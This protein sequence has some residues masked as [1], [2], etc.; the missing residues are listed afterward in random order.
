MNSDVYMPRPLYD[1]LIN[2]AQTLCTVTVK[3]GT[4]LSEEF[5]QAVNEPASAL[6]EIINQCPAVGAAFDGNFHD[7]DQHIKAEFFRHESQPEATGVPW[8]VRLTYI[9]T[10]QTVES[11]SKPSRDENR[12]VAAQGLARLVARRT[13]ELRRTS[14]L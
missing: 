1:S 12:R 8:G 13:A 2:A 9:P 6:Q 4:V 10:G 11:Y 7:D 14:S 5:E 3:M